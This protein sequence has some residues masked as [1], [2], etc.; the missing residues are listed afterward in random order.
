MI[1]FGINMIRASRQKDGGQMFP[2]HTFQNFLSIFPNVFFIMLQFN[3]CSFYRRLNFVSFKMFFSQLF[4]EPFYQALGII[5]RQE[6]LKKF[7]FFFAQNIHIAPN[8]FCIRSNHWAVIMIVRRMGCIVDVIGNAG[9]E[10]LFYAA[11]DK[12]HNMSVD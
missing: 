10:N 1:D 11:P 3:I 8:I 6:W 9:I 4:N 5:K 2:F 7:D 12:I